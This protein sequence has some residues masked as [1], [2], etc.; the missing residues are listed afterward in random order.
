LFSGSVP[1]VL[2]RSQVEANSS[3]RIA[4]ISWRSPVTAEANLTH[5]AAM[6]LHPL[7][8]RHVGD[9][10]VDQV[11]GSLRHAPGPG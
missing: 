7:P 6:R 2:A 9:D 11:S 5:I 4:A 3:P 1:P 10:V 8:H